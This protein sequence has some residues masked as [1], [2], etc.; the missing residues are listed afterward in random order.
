MRQ[1]LSL[2]GAVEMSHL[3]VSHHFWLQQYSAYAFFSSLHRC[4]VMRTD[5]YIFG[6]LF[7]LV[8]FWAIFSA[9][10]E[11]MHRIRRISNSEQVY[12]SKVVFFCLLGCHWLCILK[13]LMSDAWKSRININ[14]C[15]HQTERAASLFTQ[16]KMLNIR[17]FDSIKQNINPNKPN[18]I[19]LKKYSKSQWNR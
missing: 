14:H 12:G 16:M 8:M 3:F 1:S 19:P 5:F 10:L 6:C 15:M 2:S 4:H 13:C 18:K 17:C 11:R 9:N 7:C